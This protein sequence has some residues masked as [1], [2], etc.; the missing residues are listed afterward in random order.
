MSARLGEGPA[1]RI[2][3]RREAVSMRS[4]D[5]WSAITAGQSTSGLEGA[6]H[7]GAIILRKTCPKESTR[8]PVSSRCIDGKPIHSPPGFLRKCRI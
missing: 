3:K 6:L 8:D 7:L 4:A 5:L 2:N 1:K